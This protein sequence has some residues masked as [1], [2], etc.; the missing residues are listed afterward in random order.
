MEFKNDI[1]ELMPPAQKTFSLIGASLPS[2]TD[3]FFRAKQQEIIDQYHG[4]RLFMYETETTD[5]QHWFVLTDKPQANATFETMLRAH[6]Y[7]SALMY[8]NAIVDLSWTLCYVC[9]EF[10]VNRNGKRVDLRGMVPLEN[11]ASLLRSAENLVTAPTAEEN[12]FGYLKRMSPEFENAIDMIINFWNAFSDTPVRRKYNYC[13]HKGKPAYAEISNKY[14]TRMMAIYFEEK[15][16]GKKT[17]IASDIR[18]VRW[19][20]SLSESI[21]ELLHFD[22]ELLYPYLQKLF[23]ELE[24]VIKPSPFI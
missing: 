14:S 9:A 17:Q 1:R 19:E 16:S 13:K 3:L 23:V 22:N 4:A 6:F 20:F 2:N 7:E 11:A 10:A 24:K 15:D 21:D 18:D 12:P 5:W 8:Y